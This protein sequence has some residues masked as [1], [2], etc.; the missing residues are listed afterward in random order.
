MHLLAERFIFVGVD[1][2]FLKEGV[3]TYQ[4]TPLRIIISIEPKRS[5][6]LYYILNSVQLDLVRK[7]FESFK[8]F[9]SH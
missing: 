2:G 9:L 1:W 8:V 4:I 6:S 5:V 7:N 3:K